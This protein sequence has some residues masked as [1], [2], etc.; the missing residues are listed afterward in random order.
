MFP[1]QISVVVRMPVS[2]EIAAA[3]SVLYLAL[4]I[5]HPRK[6]KKKKKGW[7]RKFL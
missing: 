1:V 3:A 5:I 6:G 4:S 7:V 2:V